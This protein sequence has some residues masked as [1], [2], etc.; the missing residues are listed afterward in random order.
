MESI[1]IKTTENRK[2]RL[3]YTSTFFCLTLHGV[4]RPVGS[5]TR[6]VM[7]CYAV[8][9]VHLFATV[10]LQ[11]ELSI[12]SNFQTFPQALLALFR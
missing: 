8:V 4:S 12:H 5:C 7:C 6:Q 10:A 9:G 2:P 3:I 11:A 1:R